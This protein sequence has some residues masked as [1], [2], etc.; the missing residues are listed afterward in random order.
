MSAKIKQSTKVP[1]SVR[2]NAPKARRSGQYYISKR[3]RTCGGY[4]IGPGMR[5]IE[6]AEML[7]SRSQIIS[8]KRKKAQGQVNLYEFQE[9]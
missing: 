8:R 2:Y 5:Y 4:I 9:A 6:N 3:S 1:V 7:T